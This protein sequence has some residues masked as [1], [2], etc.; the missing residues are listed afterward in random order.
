ML[1]SYGAR[2]NTS[3]TLDLTTSA[4]RLDYRELLSCKHTLKPEQSGA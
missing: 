4:C 3:R 1:A 2:R